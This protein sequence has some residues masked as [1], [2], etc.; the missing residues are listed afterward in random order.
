MTRVSRFQE[1][2]E[3]GERKRE[4]EVEGGRWREER[5]K[6]VLLLSQVPLAINW[7]IVGWT[8]CIASI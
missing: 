8:P 3:A 4:R 5:E 6:V 2:T 1:V 7:S